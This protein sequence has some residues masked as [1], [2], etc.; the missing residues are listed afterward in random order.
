LAIIA[1]SLGNVAPNG[2]AFTTSVAAASKIFST[3]YRD[4]P[5]NPESDEGEKLDHVE[6]TIELRGIKH[7][8]PS[9]PEVAVINDMNLVIPAG[10][11]T[12]LVGAS[13]SGKSTIIGLVERFYEPVNGQVFL[14][15][16]DISK[17]NLKWLRENISLVSQEPIL[18]GTTIYGNVCHGLIGTKYENASEE[19]KRVLVVKACEMSNADGFIRSLPEGYETNVGERGFLLSGGQKQRIAIA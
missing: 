16:H 4:S 15:G 12:A 17:L 10:K 7:I 3:I 2:Q 14:D 9:R 8:Y 6:G 11:V 18:F 19:E 13:G 1:F 5:L